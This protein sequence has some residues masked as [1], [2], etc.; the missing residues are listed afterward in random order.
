MNPWARFLRTKRATC[1]PGGCGLD[2]HAAAQ[3]R[4]LLYGCPLNMSALDRA[5]LEAWGRLTGCQAEG[6]MNAIVG[7]FLAPPERRAPRKRGEMSKNEDDNIAVKYYTVNT[8]NLKKPCGPEGVAWHGACRRR[9][10][11]FVPPQTKA[12][13]MLPLSALS[14]RSLSVASRNARFSG[15]PVTGLILA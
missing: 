4:D 8:G 12:W 1:R 11:S 5:R 10:H 13:R 3:R 9:T 15:E 7:N 14:T 6:A 2:S